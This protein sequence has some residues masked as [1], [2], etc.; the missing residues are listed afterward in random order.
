MKFHQKSEPSN[1]F[2]QFQRWLN[3]GAT[4]FTRTMWRHVCVSCCIHDLMSL[5]DDGGRWGN[6]PFSYDSN[7]NIAYCGVSSPIRDMYEKVNHVLHNSP[8][9]YAVHMCS[10]KLQN[11]KV[12]LQLIDAAGEVY[13]GYDLGMDDSCVQVIILLEPQNR[14]KI[15]RQEC[16]KSPS[17]HQDFNYSI[18]SPN[19]ANKTDGKRGL[20]D[21]RSRHEQ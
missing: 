5:L 3:T 10:N 18:I 17:C 14:P 20:I 9:F 2:D 21:I 8:I 1:T 6:L 7:Q 19:D 12:A 13:Q 16:R 11:V 15:W 4:C